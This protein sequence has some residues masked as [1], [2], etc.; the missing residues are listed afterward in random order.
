MRTAPLLLLSMLTVPACAHRPPSPAPLPPPPIPTLAIADADTMLVPAAALEDTPLDSLASDAELP[1][2]PPGVHL[3]GFELPIQYNDQVSHY[4][5]AFST[6]Y[7]DVFGQWLVRQG[8][9]EAD[10]TARL[11]AHDEPVEL[12]YLALIE[13]GYLPNARSRA[14]AVGIWQFMAGTARL[15]G[16]QVDDWVD[17]RRDPVRATEAALR[18]LGRLYDRFGSWY[19]A[20]AAYNSGAGRVSRV[21]AA[22][23]GSDSCYTDSTFWE[24]Q[25]ALPAETRNYVPMLL[26][27]AI[28]GRNRAAFG[29]GDLAPDLPLSF[30][31]VTVPDAT[32]LDVL[33]KAAGTTPAVLASL[34][35][36]FYRGVTPPRQAVSVRIP[37][38]RRSSFYTA[39][40]R[41]PPS[42]RVRVRIHVVKAGETLSGIGVRYGV[43]AAVLQRANH[44]TRPRR[45]QIGQKLLIPV[46]AG[47]V[48]VASAKNTGGSHASARAQTGAGVYVVQPGDTVWAIARRH[49]I[50]LQDLLDWNGLDPDTTIHP[51]DRLRLR[52]RSR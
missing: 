24:I 32:E 50:D 5:D 51:G 4:L 12:L 20:A 46:P 6:R 15:E 44:I 23:L 43:S 36:R 42:E 31:T 17:E 28:I 7:H 25:D 41:I 37:V 52:P 8:R 3:T 13:S 33:A 9:Y 19:L 18:H 40:A 39:Y 49:G 29:F 11:R 27:A 21:L 47:R 26:A 34:N 38:G 2:L 1:G 45:L 16:L 22:R 14:R 48:R 30:D 10:F 35:P